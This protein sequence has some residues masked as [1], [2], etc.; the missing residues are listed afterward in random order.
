MKIVLAKIVLAVITWMI[1]LVSFSSAE[2]ASHDERDSTR[3]KVGLVLAGGGAKGASHVGVIKVLE[4][5]GVRVDYIAGTSMGAIVGGLYA[6]GMNATQ[7]EEAVKSIDWEDIFDDKPAREDRD[8]RRKLD[9]EGSLIR[10]KLGFKD[11]EF[12]LPRGV[13]LGQ[14]LNFALRSLAR[15]AN[16]V[17]DFD[18]LSIPFRAV[19]ANIESGQPVIL[20]NGDL[21]NAMRA[22][23]AV[24]G[25]F[26]PIEIDGKLLVDGGLSNNVP[27]DVV[28]QM[29]AD[30]A[31]VV[32]FPV[33]LKK[34]KELNSAL[35]II[36]QSIDLLVGQN[37]LEQ[38]KTLR[39]QDIL[40][41]PKLGDIG[42]G[43]F[44]RAAD[45]IPIGEQAA[46]GVEARL[47]RLVTARVRP[48]PVTA[49]HKKPTTEPITLDFIRIVNK[50]RLSDK[51]ISSRLRLRPGDKLDLEV[52]EKDIANIYGLDYFETVEY[53]VVTEGEKSGIAIVATEKTTGLGS[54]R[55]GLDLDNNFDGESAYDLSVRYQQ[56]GI[57][58]LGGELIVEGRVGESLGLG[59]AFLQPLDPATRYFVTP[60]YRYLARNVPTF[61][62][63]ER[64]AEFRVSTSV[65]GLGIARQ[66]N[67]WGAIRT[68][69][70]AGWGWKDVNVGPA[71]LQDEDFG[72]GKYFVRLDYDTLDN[73]HF[74]NRGERA[75]ADF[76]RSTGV[77]GG[78]RTFNAVES[79]GTIVRT[80]DKD[81]VLFSASGGWTFNGVAPTQDL[82]PLGGFGRLAGFSSNELSGQDFALGQA[83]YY[84][85]IGARP[86]S[87]GVP[88]YVG[89]ALEAG[90]VWEDR[91]DMAFDDVIVAGSVFLGLDSPIGPVYLAYGHAE[92]GNDAVYL[93]LGQ[94]F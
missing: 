17:D 47:R 51:L 48:S 77:L 38:L 64:T 59:L 2:A 10:Y 31:I 1:V 86:G 72:I 34:R 5:L 30:I 80:W 35:S 15:Q 76:R 13:I 85:N 65:F 87:F 53:R 70:E 52:L 11:G 90:N 69:I 29:G 28:R 39:K 89:G 63:G 36:L 21:A 14:K 88:V 66:L 18:K 26:P 62:S 54:F 20:K 49:N 45:A 33:Q 16:G 41:I 32:S 12:Q 73:I 4:E 50:S 68:G 82:F 61:E 7:L 24:S 78:E 94:P 71:S 6:S 74:P 81:T 43:S 55:F 37:S 57:N 75:F 79:R 60:S 25:V 58:D 19:A 27:I 40:I 9:D 93:F 8:F 83:I 23:M 22:S 92:G 42:A 3:P 46:M 44:D 91:S 56:E 67:N 84:R